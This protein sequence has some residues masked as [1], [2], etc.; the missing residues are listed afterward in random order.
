MNNSELPID[1]RFAVIGCGSIGKRHISNLALLGVGEILAF[2]TA[3][4]RRDEAARLGAATVD[5]LDALWAHQPSVCVITAPTSL[6]LALAREGAQRGCHLFIEKP[7]SHSWDGVEEL[8]EEVRRREL[9]TLVGCNMRFQPGLRAV[10]KLLGQQAIGRVIGARVEVGQY[11]P[12]WH[13]GEDYRKGYSAR[14]DLGGGIILD[15]IHEIDYICWLLGEVT[16]VTCVAGKL[17]GLEIDTEDLAA[18]ILRFECGAVGEVHLD[19]LQRAYSRNCQIIGAEGTIHWDYWA[20]LVRWYSASERRWEHIPNPPDW[21]P[22]Q[23]YIDEMKH[24]LLCLAREENPA[25]DVFEGA[26]DLAIAL[27]A[28]TS[29]REHSWIELKGVPH[30]S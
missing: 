6:H 8:L 16:G 24:F 10:K 19:Y 7:L 11:L 13:P 4:E 2:D 29:A 21:H 28:K 22:N 20:K 27:A 5:S 17:S 25:L 9:I 12:D 18:L 15:A 30:G 3:A 1:G 23:M 26:R 14:R